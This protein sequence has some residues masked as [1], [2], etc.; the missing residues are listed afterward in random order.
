LGQISQG[1]S[2]LKQQLNQ[3]PL[4]NQYLELT[5]P[6]DESCLEVWKKKPQ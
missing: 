6:E 5:V 2:S 4:R 3:Q 1:N